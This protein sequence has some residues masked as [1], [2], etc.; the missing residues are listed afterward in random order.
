MQTSWT[1][2]QPNE[3]ETVR[4]QFSEFT[5]LGTMIG[6]YCGLR[7]GRAKVEFGDKIRFLDTQTTFEVYN[8]NFKNQH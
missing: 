5:N 3:N 6:I 7:G 2:R 4:I 1:E 8:L